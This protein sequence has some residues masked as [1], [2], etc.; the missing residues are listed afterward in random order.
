[1]IGGVGSGKSRVASLLA[2]RGAAVVDADAVGHELLGESEILSRI[3]HRFGTVVLESPGEGGAAPRRIDRRA[4]GAIVFADPMALRDLEAILHPAMRACFQ[5]TIDRLTRQQDSTLIVLDAAILLEAGWDDLC[6]RVVF[7]DAPRSE[8][9]RRVAETRGW[10]EATFEARE[11]AQWPVDEKR[12]RADGI[13]ANDSGA[14]QLEG[15]VDRRLSRILGPPAS[16]E[17]S[18]PLRPEPRAGLQA[19]STS[20]RLIP[21]APT[22]WGGRS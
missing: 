16:P 2:A 17:E 21:D 11:R 3:V 18:R 5:A 10:S 20:T 15:E 19:G 12:R 8:R 1:L 4:L 14:D 9:L 7:V 13:I 22:S 6:D